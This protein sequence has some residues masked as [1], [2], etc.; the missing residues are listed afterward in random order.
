MK[1]EVV[2]NSVNISLP[3]SDMTFL[4]KTSKNM[5]WEAVSAPPKERN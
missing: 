4:R 1:T 5:G 3:K 2:M